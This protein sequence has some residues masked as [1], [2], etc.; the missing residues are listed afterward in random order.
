MGEFSLKYAAT[1]LVFSYYYVSEEI[2]RNSIECFNGCLEF[3]GI[4][5]ACYVVKGLPHLNAKSCNYCLSSIEYAHVPAL[6]YYNFLSHVIV[7]YRC[8]ANC[9]LLNVISIPVIQDYVGTIFS[10][11]GLLAVVVGRVNSAY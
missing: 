6:Q 2:Q 7:W 9:I 11:A 8:F 10:H 3:L 5:S 1:D 4:L